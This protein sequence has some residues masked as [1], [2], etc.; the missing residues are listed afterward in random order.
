MHEGIRRNNSSLIDSVLNILDWSL[1]VG[2]DKNYGGI[3]YFVDAEG[4]PPI[5]LEHD[6]KLW[7]PHTE[8][9]YALLLAYYLTKE[10]KY[11]DW[12]RKVHNYVFAHFPH[13]AYGEWFG[14]LHYDGTIANRLKNSLL[15]GPFHIPRAPLQGWKILEKMKYRDYELEL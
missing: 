9:L 13:H 6:M 11:S 10:E 4:K 3:L 5:Q 15:K 8:A 7:W 14:Y 12:Y 1:E 2:W